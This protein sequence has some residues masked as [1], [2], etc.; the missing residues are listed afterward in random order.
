MDHGLR[1]AQYDAQVSN[2]ERM[3][4]PVKNWA[5]GVKKRSEL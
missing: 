2:M 1:N 3:T 5:E 4:E